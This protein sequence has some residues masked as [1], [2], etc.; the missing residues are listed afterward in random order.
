M[1]Q[2]RRGLTSIE[3]NLLRYL[4]AHQAKHPGEHCLMP[5]RINGQTK[6]Y[7]RAIE[8]LEAQGY[9]KV[10]RPCAHYRTWIV[11]GLNMPE[12][13]QSASMQPRGLR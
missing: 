1:N 4:D 11:T 7:I 3:R 12:Q 6:D 5:A 10:D 8:Y 13:L 9:I 2:Y